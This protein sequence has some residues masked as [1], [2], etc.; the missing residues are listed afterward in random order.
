MVKNTQVAV[1]EEA[2]ALPAYLQ[3][4]KGPMR[5][6]TMGSE[7]LIIPRIKLLQAINPEV[8]AFDDAKP[9]HFWH[10]VM[11]SDLGEELRFIPILARK[12]YILFAPRGDSRTVLARAFDGVHWQPAN[13]EFEVKIKGVPKPVKWKTATTVA[14]S[15]LSEFGSSNPGDPQSPPAATLIYEY[16]AYLPDFPDV[17]PVLICLARS[18]IKKGRSLNAKMEMR[19]MKVPQFA[20]VYTAKVTEE[21]SPEGSY[22]GWDFVSSGEATQDDFE[23]ASTLAAKFEATTFRAADEESLNEDVKPAD[24]DANVPF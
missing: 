23:I 1:K 8:T 2:G 11:N 14:A 17:S 22:F 7:D 18:G 16:L 20:Q 9:G 24:A 3:D 4:Y 15:K 13:E 12:H 10:N 5:N 21:Q 6:S 19:S